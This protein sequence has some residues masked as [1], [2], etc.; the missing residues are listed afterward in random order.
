MEVVF[1]LKVTSSIEVY[2][3]EITYTLVEAELDFAPMLSHLRMF[4]SE[5]S[6]QE[7]CVV[8]TMPDGSKREPINY[9]NA[10]T[11]FIS[12]KLEVILWELAKEE[13]KKEKG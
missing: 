5:H 13:L 8:I 3:E 11:S 10:L 4:L 6:Y 9:F 2:D 12:S 1:G 7:I